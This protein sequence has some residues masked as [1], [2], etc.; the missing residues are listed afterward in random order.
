MALS[1]TGVLHQH[2]ARPERGNDRTDLAIAVVYACSS[3][4]LAHKA[5]ASDA[6]VVVLDLEGRC[7]RAKACYPRRWCIS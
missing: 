3:L 1:E 6:D 5:T 7:C 2:P 4:E